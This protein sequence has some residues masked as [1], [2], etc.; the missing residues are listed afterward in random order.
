MQAW[1]TMLMITGAT[2]GAMAGA[3]AHPKFYAFVFGR[4]AGSADHDSEC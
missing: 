3:L 4:K 2:L 1:F